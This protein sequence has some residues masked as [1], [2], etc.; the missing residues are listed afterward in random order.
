MSTS[1]D[2]S[3]LRARRAQRQ[4]HSA[5]SQPA[6]PHSPGRPADLVVTSDMI[7]VPV[8]ASAAGEL[9][10]DEL[11][12]LGQCERAVENLTTAVWLAGKALQSI[13]DRRLH[14]RDHETFEEYV[15]ERWEISVRA[16]HQMIKE[17]P[18]A[19][20]LN[21]AL[22]KPPT[23]SHTRALLPIADQYGLDVAVDMYQQLKDR[24]G[25]EGMR[26]TAALITGVMKAVLDAAGKDAKEAQFVETARHLVST[27]ELPLTTG[28]ARKQRVALPATD[29]RQQP[30][31]LASGPNVQNFAVD[32]GGETGRIMVP[33]ENLVESSA[34]DNVSNTDQAHEF[35]LNMLAQA[36]ALERALTGAEHVG[37]YSFN[38]AKTREAVVRVL[39]RITDHLLT[40]H[41]HH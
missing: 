13:R 25:R 9:T 22:G 5:G 19:E 2:A 33:V 32:G 17:W 6:A 16:A 38:A 12:Q 10:H 15:Q 35:Y 21:M 41:P 18:L 39:T 36:G 8:A 29:V 7:P 26:L 27:G 31:P 34:K 24:A 30:R 11:H 3:A 40:P 20:G 37:P 1:D 23:A 14:R 4:T 28:P